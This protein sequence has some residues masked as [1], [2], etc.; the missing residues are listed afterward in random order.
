[1]APSPAGHSGQICR[2]ALADDSDRL[3]RL[4]REMLDTLDDFEVV[5]EASTG[6]EALA[7]VTGTAPD[8]LLLDVSMPG[9]DGLEV[10]AELRQR[11]AETLALIYSAYADN[12]CLVSHARELGA[13][14]VVEKA[15][16]PAE[17]R[18]RLRAVWSSV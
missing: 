16:T 6:E 5:G 15:S 7:L 3:R 9:M 18:S 11:G 1:M 2:I 8:L 14:D 17:L 4:V 13:V 12:P 10:L